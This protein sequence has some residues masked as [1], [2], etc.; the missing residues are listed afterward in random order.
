MPCW[1]SGE[2]ASGEAETVGAGGGGWKLKEGQGVNLADG[3]YF[4]PHLTWQCPLVLTIVPLMKHATDVGDAGT[5][6]KRPKCLPC[7][8]SFT[9]AFQMFRQTE[10]VNRFEHFDLEA[11]KHHRE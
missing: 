6:S 7:Q 9:F 11:G 3:G 4:E 10:R 2:G 5:R 1:S 8:F